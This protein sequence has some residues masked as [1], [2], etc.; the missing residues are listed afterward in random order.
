MS[1]E[2][3]DKRSER[4]VARQL[5]K[6]GLVVEPN[7]PMEQF[8]QRVSA[9]YAEANEQRLLND[10]AFRTASSEMA[11]L[12]AELEQKNS[13][14]VAALESL[15]RSQ[16]IERLNAELSSKNDALS[17]LANT[18]SLTGLL[19]R[20]SFGRSLEKIAR[21]IGKNQLLAVAVIDL[22]R[23]KLVNDT[24]GHNIGDQLLI[25]V[26]KNLKE[27]ELSTDMVARLGGDEFAFARVVES[28]AEADIFASDLSA[29]LKR[30][31]RI[32]QQL[33]HSGGSVGLAL[34]TSGNVDPVRLMRDADIAMYR[35]KEDATID[36][37][38][39]DLEFRKEVTRRCTLEREVR[40][41][42]AENDVLLVYQPIVSASHKNTVLLE[43]LSRWESPTLGVV[44]PPEFIPT[45]ERLGL[46]I[47]FGR[48][49]LVKA[50]QQ[51]RH[52]R[53]QYPLVDDIAVTVNFA[54]SQLLDHGITD[55][56]AKTLRELELD[57]RCLVIELTESDLLQDFDR[58][59]SVLS[60]L[61][62]MG[63]RVALDD[64][65]TG[66]SALAY[67][68]HIPADFLKIDKAF[69]QT[70]AT[71]ES[72]CRLT[73]VIVELAD[74]FDL[75]SIGEGVEQDVQSTTLQNYGCDY[76]Q[77][78]MYGKPSRAE[79]VPALCGWDNFATRQAA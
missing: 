56:V 35:A 58:A 26:A 66:Y 77:G 34:S 27:I 70:M 1:K 40:D 33:I 17:V 46:S 41:A 24:F 78:Y 18:D 3:M 59:V 72:V 51:V 38:V 50:C 45:I 29:R 6:S 60:E 19:N 11:E 25:N 42:V 30:P 55:F 69:V 5:R 47:N 20:Y 31:L 9:T 36:Y 76:L 32:K 44:T 53:D 49:V 63:V 65:G 57:G 62:C 15:M 39:F 2:A 48:K 61:R 37:Q 73:K 54:S 16:Q 12:N 23:F 79:E 13:Q 14:L 68:P 74:R 28:A 8:V 7:S 43:A 10:H 52:W 71:D 64:F 4:L 75:E 22:D 21:T 67:L